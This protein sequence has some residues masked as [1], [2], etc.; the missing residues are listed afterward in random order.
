MWPLHPL[1]TEPY[2]LPNGVLAYRTHD[3]QPNG[4]WKHID[5]A[6]IIAVPLFCYDGLKGLS[7]IM[8]ARQS[9]DLSIATEK[10]NRQI[11]KQRPSPCGNDDC[12]R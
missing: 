10:G 12:E 11:P 3:G 7:P 8:Q 9:I 5:A 4:Q 2:R 1:M 6:D